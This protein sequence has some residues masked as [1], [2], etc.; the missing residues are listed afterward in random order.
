MVKFRTKFIH[1]S[2]G[3]AL[4]LYL[5]ACTNKNTVTISGV[6]QAGPINGR[7]EVTTLNGKKLA[8]TEVQNGQF[9]VIFSEVPPEEAIK[10]CVT[11]GSYA[12]ES[13]EKL[14]KIGSGEEVEQI[15]NL[16]AKVPKNNTK[17]PVTPLTQAVAGSVEESILNGT[18]LNTPFSVQIAINDR[19]KTVADNLGI[20]PELIQQVPEDPQ[21]LKKE[22]N[23]PGL[24]GKKSDLEKN[25]SRAA[26][27]LIGLSKMQEDRAF[28][29][30]E[31]VNPPKNKNL[32]ELLA[33][34][35]KQVSATYDISENLQISPATQATMPL[36]PTAD[37]DSTT[38]TQTPDF[39]WSGFATSTTMPDESS[40]QS[41]EAWWYETPWW[42]TTSTTVPETWNWDTTSTA[43]E[44]T[45]TTMQGD[46]SS[47]E[48]IELETTSTFDISRQ[49][50]PE[51]KSVYN[52]PMEEGF[53]Q[54]PD[55]CDPSSPTDYD[56]SQRN[57]HLAANTSVSNSPETN[58]IVIC[59]GK[60]EGSRNPQDHTFNYQL[61]PDGNT[62]YWNW[63][64]Q[65]PFGPCEG[66]PPIGVQGALPPGCHR[67]CVEWG[68]GNQFSS[69]PGKTTPPDERILPPGKTVEDPSPDAC[70]KEIL[71]IRSKRTEMDENDDSKDLAA[72]YKCCD[73]RANFWPN[74]IPEYYQLGKDSED[75]RAACKNACANGLGAEPIY[76]PAKCKDESISVPPCTSHNA[77]RPPKDVMK[78]CN[79]LNIA[80][81]TGSEMQRRCAT[82]CYRNTIAKQETQCKNLSSDCDEKETSS[83]CNACCFQKTA[84]N[85]RY[86]CLESSICNS[87][88]KRTA[89][90]KNTKTQ[91]ECNSCCS[92]AE[93][94]DDRINC[95]LLSGA[96]CRKK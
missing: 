62:T 38:S 27:A 88:K 25:E 24:G 46:T 52:N 85:E 67:D 41:T 57:C 8:S 81:M 79:D 35:I 20:P 34:A 58:G 32:K 31:L 44:F 18:L 47:T 17:V 90:C 83:E 82:V 48:P 94:V 9:I 4:V 10:L 50:D 2:L 54:L 60:P 95:S 68:C 13:D 5:S 6:A 15:C 75:Y 91:A 66:K 45:T 37:L 19:T 93:T 92:R 36:D 11:E 61:L 56:I 7:L 73:W 40:T 80:E 26:Q 69:T 64:K 22:E 29:L 12:R 16:L 23:F 43:F 65:C 21:K 55:H 87:L 42:N 76:Q 86:N 74:N 96:A 51:A 1:F 39:P 59:G 71:E 63:G 78:S 33:T 70:L 84:L 30:S 49:C 77:P 72:C 89:E 28:S 3:F 14:V 53:C